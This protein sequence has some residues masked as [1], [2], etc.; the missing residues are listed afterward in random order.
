[1]ALKT[2]S[3][4][5]WTWSA[6]VVGVIGSLIF[7]VLLMMLGVGLGL[8]AVDV[9]TADSAPKAV[10]WAVFTW[11][12][13]SGV[14]SAFAGG[15][16]A[17]NFAETVTPEGR[18]AHALGAWALATLIVVGTAGLT[19]GGSATI[20]SNLAGPYTGAYSQFARMSEPRV[21]TTGQRPVTQA[22]LEQARRNLAM[23][24]LASF[25]A[26]LVGAGAAVAGSQW[27]PDADTRKRSARA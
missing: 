19:A 17:A 25:V 16:L 20:A 18:G 1:M 27:L 12:A 21:Q 14:A 9:P 3:F 24:T 7:Q 15:W 10:S 6:V 22:Q 26:L 2:Y 13:A 23:I 5:G 4:T 11:W 8:L